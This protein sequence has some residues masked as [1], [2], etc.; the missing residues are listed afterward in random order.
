MRPED[1]H[2]PRRGGLG[3]D[4]GW[5]AGLSLNDTRSDMKQ[6]LTHFAEEVRRA[7]Q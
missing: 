3:C 2:M 5:S 7:A 4:C 1:E 6:F